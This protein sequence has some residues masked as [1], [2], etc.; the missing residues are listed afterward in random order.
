MLVF[1]IGS[2]TRN[3]AL[4]FTAGYIRAGR[5]DRAPDCQLYL[6]PQSP[7]LRIEAS[8]KRSFCV[9][10]PAHQETANYNSTLIA[11]PSLKVDKALLV[12]H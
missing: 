3:E 1:D 2:K 7:K 10:A 4:D 12:Q 6:C 8:V 9:S 5:T 11:C